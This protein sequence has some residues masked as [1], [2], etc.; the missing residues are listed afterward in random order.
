VIVIPIVVEVW[1]LSWWN[2]RATLGQGMVPVLLLAMHGHVHPISG[3]RCHDWGVPVAHC[4]AK[5]SH[6]SLGR[7]KSNPRGSGTFDDATGAQ[8]RWRNVTQGSHLTRDLS[9]KL[10]WMEFT[11]CATK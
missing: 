7:G 8:A 10:G 5:G 4:L 3:S 2:V 11:I 6:V 9:A 1:T